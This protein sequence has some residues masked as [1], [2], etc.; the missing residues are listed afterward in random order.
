VHFFVQKY[1]SRVGRRVESI[2]ADTMRQ[3]TQYSWPGNIRELENIIERA[4]I[5][6]NSPVLRMD[7]DAL[8]FERGSPASAN[9]T[10][11]SAAAPATDGGADLNTVQREHIAQM[12]RETNWVIE[13]SRGAAHR[14]G[15]KPGT[16]RHRMKKLGIARG[17]SPTP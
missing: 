14:L 15:L 16:L 9:V 13:G 4:L 2:D 11:L 5:L 1:A 17:E 6:S 8:A 7:A 10:A 12:L 3:L